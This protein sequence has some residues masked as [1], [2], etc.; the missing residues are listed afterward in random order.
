MFGRFFDDVWKI[1]ADFW[2]IFGRFWTI[3]LTIFGRF[4]VRRLSGL[5]GSGGWASVVGALRCLTCD[6]RFFGRFLEDFLTMFGRCL[7]DFWTIL[8]DLLAIF[9]R[10]LDDVWTIF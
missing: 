5:F 6:N 10:C 3:C 4:L 2:K 1:L 9:G 8:D 7:D